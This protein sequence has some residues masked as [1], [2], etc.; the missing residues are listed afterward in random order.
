MKH[1]SLQGQFRMCAKQAGFTPSYW[2]VSNISLG[3][4]RTPELNMGSIDELDGITKI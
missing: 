2:S 4:D 1:I 3:N